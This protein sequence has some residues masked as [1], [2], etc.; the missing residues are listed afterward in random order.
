MKQVS[1]SLKKDCFEIK[2]SYSQKQSEAEINAVLFGLDSKV[3]PLVV[4]TIEIS[5]RVRRKLMGIHRAIVGDLRLV[6]TKFSGKDSNGKPAKGHRHSYFLP[7]DRDRDGRIDHILVVC[8]D[9]FSEKE[10]VALDR[11]QSIWQRDGKPD[12]RCIPIR[13]GRLGELFRP[14]TQMMSVTPFVPPRH[15]RRGRG[16]WTDWLFEQVRQEAANHGLPIPRE[17]KLAPSLATRRKEYRWIQF[18]RN[19]G[20]DPIRQGYGFVLKFSEAINGP[21]ALGY[22]AHFG[23]GQFSE[24]L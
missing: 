21:F 10:R 14:V 23:L 8:K 16:P 19:R 20:G 22:G 1:Y 7:M 4:D 5:E 3:L 11:L 17:I 12:I 13:W 18:R 6:S 24:A 9:P 2:P 15:Y